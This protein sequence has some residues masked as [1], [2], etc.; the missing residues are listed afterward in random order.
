M[1][2]KSEA[3]PF[4]PPPEVPCPCE[5]CDGGVLRS[6]GRN[7]RNS[8]TFLVCSVCKC[9]YHAVDTDEQ[10]KRIERDV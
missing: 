2:C 4:D 3:T 5:G 8:H 10:A 6:D 1:P 9:Y 7:K